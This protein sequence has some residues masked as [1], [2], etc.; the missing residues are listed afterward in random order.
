LCG[1]K[2]LLLDF[3]LKSEHNRLLP[4]FRSLLLTEGF[5]QSQDFFVITPSLAALAFGP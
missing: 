4:R 2:L 5:S 1:V 3:L